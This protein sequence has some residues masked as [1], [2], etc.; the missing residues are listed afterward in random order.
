MQAIN[1]EQLSFKYKHQASLIDNLDLSIEAGERFGIFGPNGAGKTT[2]MSLLAGLLPYK[3]GSI[4]ILGT[5]VE[6][7]QNA[8]NKLIGLVPQD[9]SF[10][11]DLSP[12]EN[13][14]FFGAWYGL[15]QR[16][17]KIRT[18]ELLQTMGLAQVADKPVKTF[19]GG[20]KRRVNLAIGVMHRPQVLF[21]DEPTVGVDVQSRNAI[22]SFLKQINEEGTTL[23]Y[24]SHQLAEAEDLC[25]SVALFDQGSIIAKDSLSNLLHQHQKEGLE[26]LFLE[27]TGRAYRD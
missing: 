19:S 15:D 18:A 3:K 24:T 22:I 13:M 9:F 17:T 10:Y 5:E 16:S 26:G 1:V 27:L 7:N 25:N 14:D 8:V 21:L 20:M 4:K 11:E 23:V 2:L 6:M 12:E